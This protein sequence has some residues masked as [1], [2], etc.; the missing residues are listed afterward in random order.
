MTFDNVIMN[1]PYDGN[2]HLKVLESV[3]PM[4]SG[5]CV[6]LS[7]VRW[8]QDPLTR[9]K[10]GTSD[11]TTFEESV[12]SYISEL[13]VIPANEAN[14][15]FERPILLQPLGIYKITPT[16]GFDYKSFNTN[17]IL[18]KV[19]KNNNYNSLEV[20]NY[21]DSLK[22][23]VCLNTMAPSMKYGRPYYETLKNF[24]YFID[25]KNQNGYNYREAKANCKEATRGDVSKTLCAVF[26]DPEEVK[27]C[28]DAF[29][30]DFCRYC[31]SASV[32]DIHVYQ[33][34]LPWVNNL[35]NPR[36]GLVGY[37]SNWTDDDFYNVFNL[38]DSEI[39][40]IHLAMA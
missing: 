30:T 16:G 9:F 6:N 18:E 34:F 37:K 10:K 33:R 1:P 35:P 19:I 15:F 26:E 4:V 17:T 31:I 20:V 39:Q 2:L 28:W 22:N 13:D 27:N 7:P 5:T 14:S 32:V 23:Y 40:A 24:G 8:L 36:T 25:G 3:I 29:N 11:Y 38:T 21:T 12:S